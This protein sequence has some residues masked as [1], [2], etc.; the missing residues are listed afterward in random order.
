MGIVLSIIVFF[1]GI[2]VLGHSQIVEGRQKEKQKEV[3]LSLNKDLA[4]F[5]KMP[6]LTSTDLLS[7]V[8]VD[9]DKQR[10]YI[11]FAEDKEGEVLQKPYLGMPYRLL[12]FAIKDLD[13]VAIVE[14]GF[15]HSSYGTV[16][17]IAKGTMGAISTD[18]NKKPV[19]KVTSL[20]LLL[21]MNHAKHS[22][23]QVNF[24]NQ[25]YL[26]LAKSSPEFETFQREARKWFA[27]L[28]ML[29]GD[30]P[31]RIPEPLQPLQDKQTFIQTVKA[32]IQTIETPQKPE[33][34]ESIE[35]KVEKEQLTTKPLVQEEAE[36][37]YFDRLVAENKRQLSERRSK[38][39]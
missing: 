29:M 8:A 14:D 31:E 13:G 16:D 28:E 17:D 24:Y 23:F 21:K 5:D 4:D 27:K 12:N 36:L 22:F 3:L 7:R 38:E 15:I 39:K 18:P 9:Y 33:S 35:S 30:Q 2:M 25:P 20:A 34:S 6:S 37:S 19:D 32:P 11:W 26:P 10:L 1:I